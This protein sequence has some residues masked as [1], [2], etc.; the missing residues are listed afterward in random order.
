[1]LTFQVGQVEDF[2]LVGEQFVQEIN[3][4]VFVCLLAKDFLEAKVGERIDVFFCYHLAF[5]LTTKIR[6]KEEK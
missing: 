3:E 2:A 6:K 1:M 4:Q 5:L